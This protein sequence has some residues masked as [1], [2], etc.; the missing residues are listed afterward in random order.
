MHPATRFA[1]LALT[2]LLFACS[3]SSSGAEPGTEAGTEAGMEA[4]T[5]AGGDGA[6]AGSCCPPDP[7]PGCCMR[8]GGWNC[9]VVCDGIP[10]PSDPAWRLVKD[11]HGCDTWSSA[12][13][14]GP[15]CG[16]PFDGGKDTAP[17]DS[18]SDVADAPACPTL[19]PVRRTACAQL[20]QVCFYGC[21]IV[22]HCTADGWDYD[23]TVDGG[24]PC[25]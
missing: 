21:G 20:D 18:G 12:G 24:P 2:S 5:E 10:I 11:E 6:D 1:L 7:H 9:A 23:P 25:P 15:L 13:S 17:T 3:S 16:A 14:T 4:G 19:L 8:Y 22:M